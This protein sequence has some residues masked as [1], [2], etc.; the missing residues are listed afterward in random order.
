MA[1][2]FLSNNPVYPEWAGM[3]SI[4]HISLFSFFTVDY[5]DFGAAIVQKQNPTG[6]YLF[7]YGD[8]ELFYVDLD[9]KRIVYTLPG[10]EKYVSFEA[11]FGL[12]QISTVKYNLGV[13]MKRTN[14]TPSV[15]SKY[16]II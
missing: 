7:D 16:H 14:N 10:L 5:F 3:S 12:Q 9:N 15:S 2:L 1:L 11:Q 8:S 4:F 13:L 6:E